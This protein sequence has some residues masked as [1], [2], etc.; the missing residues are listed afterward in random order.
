MCY[1]SVALTVFKFDSYTEF[2][3]GFLKSAPANGRGLRLRW[4]NAMGIHSAYL[5]KVLKGDANIS[6][7]QA[8]KLS[9][10]L[11]FDFLEK[12]Y[13][14][15]LV[16]LG[17]AGCHESQSYFRFIVEK[18]QRES[19]ELSNKFEGDLVKGNFDQSKY[20]ASW[21]YSAIHL[22]CGV[23]ELRGP[24][25]VVNFLNLPIEDSEEALQFLFESNL[26]E[27]VN[28]KFKATKNRIHLD[29]SSP[30]LAKKLQN[31]RLKAI[32]A[33]QVQS[34]MAKGIHYSSTIAVSKENAK[35]I[36]HV[37][38]EAISSVHSLVECESAEEIQIMNL[39]FFS[40]Y[41]SAQR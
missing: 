41:E 35:K 2:L 23:V 24:Q 12:E 3:N 17:R 28:G 36:R 26:I 22:L 39:D 38:T 25:D 20:F 1:P 31:F 19:L 4:A 15:A 8:V 7:D 14:I 30:N 11:N 33:F 40:V 6:V 29:K 9:S 16:N 18:L 34:K 5:T 27:K 21:Y 37:L 32:E 13:F 10:E